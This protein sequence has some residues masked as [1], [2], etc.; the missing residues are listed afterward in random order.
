MIKNNVLLIDL[1]A[2]KRLEIILEDKNYKKLVKKLDPIFLITTI[3]EIGSSDCLEL[4]EALSSKQVQAIIDFSAWQEDQ[5][6]LSKVGEWLK[7]LFESGHQSALEQIH[8]LDREFLGLVFKKACHIYDLSTG[9]EPDEY[10][11]L[12]SVCPDG[13]FLICFSDHKELEDLGRVLHLFL[14]NLYGIDMTFALNLLEDIK[15][16]QESLLEEEA[17]KFRNHRLA[18]FGVLS[19][20]ENLILLA[21]ITPKLLTKLP[22]NKALTSSS[23]TKFSNPAPDKY[24]FLKAALL[25]LEASE[26]T[27]FQDL[28]SHLGLNFHSLLSQDF[29]DREKIKESLV[30]TSFLIDLGLWRISKGDIKAAQQNLLDYGPK[31]LLRL[32]RSILTTLRKSSFAMLNDDNLLL[33]KAFECA[34]SPLRE[35]AKAVC[36]KEPLYYEGLL[37]ARKLTAGYFNSHEQL[38]ASIIALKELR[39]R[40]LILGPKCLGITKENT[41]LNH[42]TMF[43]RVIINRFLKKTPELNE[44]TS[45]DLTIIFSDENK[46]KLSNS[47]KDFF[48]KQSDELWNKLNKNNHEYDI[49]KQNI[50]D[51]VTTI[52]IKL[53]QNYQEIL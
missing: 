36:S 30:Y 34:D 19:R 49:S 2:K 3:N 29:D 39:N 52:V 15:Y 37:D 20:E 44:I 14:E 45:K 33:N 28:I 8:K 41:I 25:N 4:I 1:D 53:E 11:N 48:Y 40:S 32:G 16:D 43:A 10:S 42:S 46:T 21:E 38:Q 12:Y 47:I 6:N 26:V 31:Q 17:Y 50:Y 18:D 24:I 51:F 9:E 22:S 27:Y 13:R 5:I 23:L 7:L 35:V